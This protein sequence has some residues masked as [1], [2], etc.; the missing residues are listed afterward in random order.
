MA[1]LRE[2]KKQRRREAI[3]QAGMQLFVEKG[4]NKT[5]MEDIAAAVDVSGQTVFNYFPSKQT[6]LF[7]FL[8]RADNSA[9]EEVYKSLDPA[10]DPVD[11]LCGLVE[12]ITELELQLM[13]A[14]L[15][16]EIL[17]MIMFHPKDELPET[18]ARGNDELVA[19]IRKFLQAMLDAGSISADTDLDFAAFMINDYGHL[20]LVRLVTSDEPDW[21]AFR[22]N[23]RSS[24]TLFVQGMLG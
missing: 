10:G 9:L 21:D 13:P 18:Y 1:G 7:E 17:P 5:R 15:W 11:V 16:R 20:Q 12:I 22:Q 6:I 3:A 8:R 4:F 24:I 23:V 14:P 19:E 2:Q